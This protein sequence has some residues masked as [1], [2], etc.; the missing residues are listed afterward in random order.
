MA[1]RARSARRSRRFNRL[2]LALALGLAAA[3]FQVSL[4]GA[5]VFAAQAPAQNTCGLLTSD[6]VQTLVPEKDKASNGMADA[7]PDL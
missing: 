4:P 1:T 2:T 5:G 6:E 7:F 3:T